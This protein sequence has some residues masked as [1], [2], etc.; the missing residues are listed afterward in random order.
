MGLITGEFLAKR[1]DPLT[2]YQR[3]RAKNLNKKANLS[4]LC[5]FCANLQRI[6]IQIAASIDWLCQFNRVRGG[7]AALFH[8]AGCVNGLLLTKNIINAGFASLQTSSPVLHGLLWMLITQT[9]GAG[10]STLGHGVHT[11]IK[12]RYDEKWYSSSLNAP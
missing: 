2:I 4:I 3:K 6:T 12:T 5:Q 1:H 7:G 10:H 11:F 8:S 9:F